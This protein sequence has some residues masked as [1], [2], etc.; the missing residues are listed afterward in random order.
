MKEIK[1]KKHGDSDKLV[2][3]FYVVVVNR[4]CWNYTP[5]YHIAN[6]GVRSSLCIYDEL[7]AAKRSYTYFKKRYPQVKLVCFGVG[8]ATVLKESDDD[9]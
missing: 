2:K 8:D 6:T 5:G 3:H 4:E 1:V 7:P 9:D